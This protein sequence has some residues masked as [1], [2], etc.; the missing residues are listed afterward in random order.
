MNRFSTLL[1]IAVISMPALTRAASGESALKTIATLRSQSELELAVLQIDQEIARW[2]RGQIQRLAIKDSA[3]WAELQLADIECATASAFVDSLTRSIKWLEAI[4]ATARNE[5]CLKLASVFPSQL[6]VQDGAY[7][8][9]G[10]IPTRVL[11]KR[12]G[13]VVQSPSLSRQIKELRNSEQRLRQALAQIDPDSCDPYWIRKTLDLRRIAAQRELAEFELTRQNSRSE[14]ESRPT[15]GVVYFDAT[16]D[17]QLQNA[18]R[19]VV[20]FENDHATAIDVA[21]NELAVAKRRFESM[22]KLAEN[23]YATTEEIETAT[24]N[25]RAA[26]ENIDSIIAGFSIS[27]SNDPASSVTTPHRPSADAI[28]AG[29]DSANRSL[30][31]PTPVISAS[32]LPHQFSLHKCRNALRAQQVIMERR[33]KYYRE[34]QARLNRISSEIANLQE[35]Q[36]L[37]LQINLVESVIS[38]LQHRYQ[39]VGAEEKRFAHQLAAQYRLERLLA[40]NSELPESVRILPDSSAVAVVG[41][42]GVYPGVRIQEWCIG[43]IESFDGLPRI[44]RFAD[45]A[46]QL[47][48]RLGPRATPLARYQSRFNSNTVSNNS[49]SRDRFYSIGRTRWLLNPPCYL[50]PFNQSDLLRSP[51]CPRPNRTSLVHYATFTPVLPSY[52]QNYAF[53]IRR[54]DTNSRSLPRANAYGGPWYL[55]GSTTNYR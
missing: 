25:F 27:E 32:A 6:F 36:N 52:S 11:S 39:A 31:E 16:F 22:S 47:S 41:M 5:E 18:I 10:W 43:Y 21:R 2:R 42:V 20:A 9:V 8:G 54:L 14:A 45:G 28:A 50:V 40:T 46:F 51:L 7:R 33:L 37:V 30:K 12:D 24:T 15:V 1:A 17:D 35:R 13:S 26:Q 29:R 3:T 4:E 48:D 44:T 53:G 38:D 19:D 55:P 34:R 49:T 23:G